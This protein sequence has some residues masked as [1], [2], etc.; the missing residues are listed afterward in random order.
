[1]IPELKG[2]GLFVF[3][4]PGGAKPVLAFIKL[5]PEL[6]DYMVVSDRE[7]DFFSDFNIPVTSYTTGCEGHILK[8]FSPDFIFT[9]T[10]Y[11]SELDKTYIAAGKKAKIPVYSFVDHWTN[12]SARFQQQQLAIL[13][14]LVLL[15][16]N[17]AKNMALKEGIPEEQLLVIGNPYHEY[18]KSWRPL[19]SRSAFFNSIGL[20]TG[21]K[22]VIVFGPDPLSNVNGRIKFGFDEIEGVRELAAIADKLAEDYI[23]L[24]N[25]H[26]NQKIQELLPF[27]RNNLVVLKEKLDVNTLIFHADL[28]LGIF[29][30]FLLEALVM[31][32]TVIRFF[33]TSINNDPFAHMAVGQI[34]V[35]KEALLKILTS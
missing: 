19:L 28:V 33:P 17:H 18:L 34:V 20:N 16:D 31:G 10:S 24:L 30:S 14:D 4:D 32:K 35:G 22:K 5:N 13:P 27:E 3:S 11:T 6:Q 29:S 15:V 26:P 8:R 2:K 23:I 21:S 25:P 9:G 7:Y 1:M 12:I